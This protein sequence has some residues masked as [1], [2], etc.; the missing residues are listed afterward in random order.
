MSFPISG[1]NVNNYIAGPDQPGNYSLYGVSVSQSSTCNVLIVYSEW[2]TDIF[3]A[4]SNAFFLLLQNH[5]G[6]LN[7]G[8]CKTKIEWMSNQSLSGPVMCLLLCLL[9]PLLSVLCM[10][11]LFIRAHTFMPATCVCVRMSATL[12]VEF[13]QSRS[14]YL[15]SHVTSPPSA[16]LAAH[17]KDMCAPADVHLSISTVY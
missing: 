7:G 17:H 6:N 15:S 5:T 2:T 8:H 11:L 1:L 3:G 14:S 9:F 12:P 4:R 16:H 10:S 13:V